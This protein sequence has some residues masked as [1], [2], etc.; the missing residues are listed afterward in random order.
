MTPYFQPLISQLSQRAAEATLSILGISNPALRQFLSEQFNQPIGKDSNNFLADPVFEAIFGWEESNFTMDRLAG[1]LLERALIDAMDK[2]PTE[3]KDYAFRKEWKPYEHQYRAWLKLTDTNPQSIVI[4]S[5]T[6][7]G[8]TECFM[9]P[10]LN[11]LVREYQQ[12]Q[13]SLVGVRALFIY[14][15]NALINSQRDRLRAW[16]DEFG[17]ALRFCLYNGNTPETTSAFNQAQTPNEIL[18]RVLLRNE[19]SPLLVTNATMLEYMLVRQNDAPILQKSQGQLRWIVLDEAHTYIGSQAAELS[20]LLRRVMHGFG[21]KADDVRFV[22]TSATIGDKGDESLRHYL[23]NLAG[24]TPDK[25]TV[26]GGKRKV[27]EIGGRKGDYKQK[28]PIGSLLE[29]DKGQQAS[30]QRYRALK[31]H[32]ISRKLREELTQG[33]GLPKTLTHLSSTLFGNVPDLEQ[34]LAWLDLCSGTTLPEENNKAG[35]PFLPLRAHLLHQVINGLWSCVDPGCNRKKDTPLADSWTFGYVYSQ[36]R[37]FCD[38]GAPVYELVFCN[39]CNSPHLQAQQTQNGQLIQIA[40]ES[41][42]EF[43]LHVETDSDSDEEDKDLS[44]TVTISEPITLAAKAHQ[45]L[46]HEFTLSRNNRLLGETENVV[47]VHF[48]NNSETEQCGHCGFVPDRGQR[49]VFRRCL[50]GTPFYVSNT[51]PTLLEF[52]QDGRYPLESPGRGRRLITFTDSRQG[53][54]RIAVKIQQDSERNRLRGLIYEMSAKQIANASSNEA[55]LLELLRKRDEF[56]A[57]AEKFKQLGLPEAQ[58]Y[59]DFAAEKQ[60]QIERTAETQPITWV[61]MINGLQ[62]NLDISKFML[63]YYRDDL[64]A[65][66]FQ[67][68]SGSRTLSE[69]LLIR[70]FNRRA[71]RQN[72]LE[73][74][75]LVAV[76]YPSLSKIKRIPSE[77]QQSNLSANDWQDFLKICLDFYVRDNFIA[78][79][80]EWVNWIGVTIYPKEL[81]K[82][83]TQE[84]TGKRINKWPLVRKGRNNRLIRILAYALSLDTDHKAHEDMLNQIMRAA[85]K[86]LTQES[87]ILTPVTGSLGYQMKPEQMAFSANQTAWICPV[88]HRLLDRTFKGITPYL[89]YKPIPETA[90]CEKVSIPILPAK[91]DFNSVQEKLA[92]V[93]GWISGNAEISR[94]RQQNLWTDLSDRILE[95]GVFFRAAEHSAQQPASRLQYFET[96]FKEQKLNVLSCST[97]M[98]MGVDIGGISAVAMNN[99]PPHSA[100]Y[101][102]RAGRAGRR[103]ENRA[104]AF[105]LCKDNP[106][107]RQVFYSPLWPFTTQIKSPYIT[108]NSSKIVQRHVNS[109]ILSYFLKQIIAVSQQ[110]NT[111]LE[112]GWFF[113]QGDDSYSQ[114]ERFCS[115]LAECELKMPGNLEQGLLNV[116]NGTVLAGTKLANLMQQSGLTINSIRDQWLSEYEPLQTE[117]NALSASVSEN[118]PYRKRV[119]RD[120]QRLKGEYLLSELATRGFLPGYGFPTGLAYFDPY[121]IHDYKPNS[122]E[123]K[124]DREDNLRR[125]RDK[126]TRDL[127]IAIREYAPGN[128]IVLNGL[129]Y[130][131]AGL[132]LSWHQPES[133]N[134][135]TQKLMT[136]WR[137]DHCG[138]I[139]HAL[140][141]HSSTVCHECGW[142]LN[143]EHKHEFIEPAGFAVDFYESP[144]TNI[145]RQHFVPFKEP[146][147]TAKDCIRT[148]PNP[149]LGLFR[150]GNQG[151]IFYHSAGEHGHGYALCWHCGRADSMTA[152]NELPEVFT[153]A[154]PHNRLRGKA[155]GQEHAQCSGNDSEFAIKPNLYLGYVYH[156]DVLEL[157]L[158]HR[159]EQQF[160]NNASVDDNKIAWTLAVAFRQ[161]LADILGINAEELGYTVK[162]TKLAEYTYPVATIVLYDKCSGGAGF[163]SSAHHDFAALFNRARHYLHCTCQS[164][165]QNCLLGFDTRFHIDH[166]DRQLALAF[167]TEDFIRAL[168]LPDDLMLLGESSRYTSET[169]FTEIRQAAAQGAT[170]LHLF[171]HGEPSSWEILSALREPLSRWQS[172]YA[173]VVLLI[174]E[175]QER[176]L[177]DVV[178]EEL[179]VL[180]RLGIKTAV[181]DKRVPNHAASVIAQTFASDRYKTFACTRLQSAIPTVNWLDDA[182][183]ILLYANDYPEIPIGRYLELSQLKPK[184]GPSDVEIEVLA[185]CNGKLTE[186]AQKFWRLMTERHI[187]LQQH[188]QNNDELLSIYYSDRYLCSPWTV[189][190][191]AEL[192]DGLK[193]IL[194]TSWNNPKLHI[195][196]APKS[197][198]DSYQKHGL[199][200]DWLDD[201]LRLAVMEAYFAA[202]DETCAAEISIDTQHG[203]IM[204]LNWRS[205]K[206][207]TL[208]FDQGVG[209]WGCD[210]KPPYFDN[211]AS[212]LEQAEDMM[213]I[214][215]ELKIR[216][217]KDFPTQVFIKER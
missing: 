173:Q 108:L 1:S 207:T 192:I 197:T 145:S 153:K 90:I 195:D 5:G 58:D 34:T 9:V 200:A 140:S 168:A 202:M 80:Y 167:L 181:T 97:T 10:V 55:E 31:D 132:A 13:Q 138:A 79:P 2:P 133:K 130:R 123:P 49:G 30:K 149:E 201:S 67:G 117:L 20:L 53:T 134:N 124:K 72:T 17:S 203:R 61:E 81:L 172:Q 74:L 159:S 160:L 65:L 166:M 29:I 85:W 116:I 69:M 143:P 51:I 156:T 32:P 196:S 214:V 193:Q 122:P 23:A 184:M 95:G 99:V 148:L 8:K 211:L 24:I 57:K 93:R 209:Y 111:K 136:A 217:H 42:D 54:A 70:E 183:N 161:A 84:M 177:S 104:L 78:V 185:E 120:L 50:L 189:I 110:Q 144:S 154:K 216:N 142:S 36:Q 83:D 174:N 89:P 75:G 18:S 27:P 40:R 44:E 179:W 59:L 162:P 52:C 26:I 7:S 82:P 4:T 206:V 155:E 3:L 87:E 191:I 22:A 43:S 101:L 62:A 135:E 146:W 64:K 178:K 16:T 66:P 190:L 208:R 86:A 151:D 198:R 33:G 94:L 112:C 170:K 37:E 194:Q 45:E 186:F 92:C 48:V 11:D 165:C 71:K 131:S 41:I 169:L 105:T 12:Q 63:I 77:W 46:T 25:V 163:A 150:S 129:V 139:D 91:H 119:T 157:Y 39:D 6:G 188:L 176:K 38:C 14:P 164:V 141:S 187:P 88:T 137:C 47:T 180:Y 68:S 109:L 152:E 15:L 102:Q 98:E 103:Q 128:D 213:S 215:S 19:P 114:V 212:A 204:Q 182:E 175:T 73:T 127:S 56:L 126:P 147:V 35:R 107:E 115:W 21:V 113:C 125:V 121:S 106:H 158:K 28:T 76:N 205:G 118:D 171:L 96:L 60:Q 199:F 210:V 100:N